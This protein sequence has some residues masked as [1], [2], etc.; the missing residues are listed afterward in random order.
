MAMALWKNTYIKEML[1]FNI[2][3]IVAKRLYIGRN[4]GSKSNEHFT[5]F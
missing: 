3:Y 2:Y 4:V 5:L 1:Y